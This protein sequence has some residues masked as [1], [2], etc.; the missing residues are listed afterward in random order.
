MVA[1]QGDGVL[2]SLPKYLQPSR[3]CPTNLSSYLRNSCLGETCDQRVW[4]GVLGPVQAEV[5]PSS[6]SWHGD[7][8]GVW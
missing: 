3:P 2:Q 7:I 4:S 8:C 5:L 6:W 1:G